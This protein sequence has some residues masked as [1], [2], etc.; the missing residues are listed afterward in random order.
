L[1]LKIFLVYDSYLVGVAT[2]RVA[3]SL[4]KLKKKFFSAEVYTK[5]HFC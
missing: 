3:I 5:K 1:R 4:L 2:P